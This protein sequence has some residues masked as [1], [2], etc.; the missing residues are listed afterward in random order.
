ME[1]PPPP[2]PKAFPESSYLISLRGFIETITQLGW[3]PEGGRNDKVPCTLSTHTHT[4]KF[5]LSK[6]PTNPVTHI[7]YTLERKLSHF[8]IEFPLRQKFVTSLFPLTSVDIKNKI[9]Y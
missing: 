9:K 5:R 4:Y 2:L 7:L 3:L 6:F 1:L 8:V